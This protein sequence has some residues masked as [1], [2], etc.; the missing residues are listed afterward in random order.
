MMTNDYEGVLIVGVPRRGTTLL[1][2]IFDS[3]PNICCPPE[4][5][6]FGSCRSAGDQRARLIPVV[7]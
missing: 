3:H 7:E 4:T 1:R 5:Y 2:R 6:L